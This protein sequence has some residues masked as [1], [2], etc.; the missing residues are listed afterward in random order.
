[1]ANEVETKQALLEQKLEA[2]LQGLRE[3]RA[4]VRSLHDDHRGLGLQ[5]AQLP[6]QLLEKADV[7]YAPAGRLR[8]LERVFYGILI[9]AMVSIGGLVAKSALEAHADAPIGTIIGE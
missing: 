8:V 3:A 5:V 4:D 9:A 6:L 7:R 2:I 1:M